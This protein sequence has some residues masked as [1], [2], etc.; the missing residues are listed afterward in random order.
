[1]QQ[2]E[3]FRR[4][5]EEGQRLREEEELARRQEA[6]R[7]Q[8][9]QE[10]REAEERRRIEEFYRRLEQEAEQRERRAEWRMR[11][12][13]PGIKAKRREL[14]QE[15][16]HRRWGNNS[17]PGRSTPVTV[18]A[19]SLTT[20]GGRGIAVTNVQITTD[21]MGNFVVKFRDG[22]GNELEDNLEDIF[23]TLDTE[24][25]N[26]LATGSS[27]DQLPVTV[28][29]RIC[30]VLEFKMVA[31]A[32]SWQDGKKACDVMPTHAVPSR[33]ENRQLNTQSSLGDWFTEGEGVGWTGERKDSNGNNEAEDETD[34]WRR[35]GRKDSQVKEDLV[36]IY[37]TLLFPFA[38]TRAVDPQLFFAD[39]D[40][41]VFSMRIRCQL[42][43]YDNRIQL[44][45]TCYKILF[46]VDSGL[47]VL[48]YPE[49]FYIISQ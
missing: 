39:P 27:F 1:M 48:L 17:T 15:I 30:H 41:A 9:E 20:R 29:S 4:R 32:A 11:R 28:R 18:A 14:Q 45:Q 37:F 6:E 49:I 2:A 36:L 47:C 31:A 33:A 7:L 19:E 25:Q 42:L 38:K 24:L 44:L 35:R 22:E 13:N 8:A 3:E 16:A 12:N 10:R 46:F 21:V 34:G 23:N 43:F 26:R 40:P 5:K